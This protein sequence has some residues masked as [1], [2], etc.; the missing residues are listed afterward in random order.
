[1][2]G[3]NRVLFAVA[4]T[5][6][7]LTG[8]PLSAGQDEAEL[9][10]RLAALEAGQQAILKELQDLKTLLQARP[11]FPPLPLPVP[12]PGAA[13][14]GAQAAPQSAPAAVPNFDLDIA[15]SATKGRDGAKLVLVEFSDFQ[16][17]FCARYS[18]ETLPQI[19][20]DYVDTGK[21]RYVFRHYPIEKLHPLALRAS[22][23]AECA[24]AQGKFW[25]MHARLFANQQLLGEADLVNHGQAVGL[26][27]GP[28]Q[29][30][31]A[32]QAGSPAKIRKDQA[33]GLRAG[34]TGTP[35]FFI[36]TMTK[37]GKVKVLRR[38]VGAH[39]IT[40]FRT[41]LETLLAEVGR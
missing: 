35:T 30:C 8:P 34:V 12:A 19:E 17:P 13:P 18:H 3:T 20:R 16:C 15:G 39:P 5:V 36:G 22:A 29:A 4:A 27:A 7:V 41:A 28:F 2:T 38:M 11:A 40:S 31:M 9:R 32:S 21:V 25:E 14:R 6:L 23:A 24:G 33:E 1:M 10:K 26:S 37:E